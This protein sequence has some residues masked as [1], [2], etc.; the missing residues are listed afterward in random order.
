MASTSGRNNIRTQPL[1]LPNGQDPAQFNIAESDWRYPGM[2]G[3]SC[4]IVLGAGT[5][6]DPRGSKTIQLV[7]TDSTMTV[8]PFN[9][10][11]AW[12]QNRLT[13]K[14]TTDATNRGQIA[15]VFLGAV[16]AGRLGI[17]QT[18]GRHGT[19]KFVNAP[20]ATPTAAG[21]IV[22]PSATNAKADC[23]AA[24]SAATYPQ[25]GVSSGTYN[26]A[27]ATCT[28]DLDVPQTT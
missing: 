25:L 17:I 6:A 9:G 12:W 21:L 26:A 11:V 19:V 10:A 20:V 28:V 1:Y 14:V 27:E 4:T 5:A 18:K 13:Y 24:G 15:G 22:I 3:G 16:T 23:L 2:I 8:A 7:R